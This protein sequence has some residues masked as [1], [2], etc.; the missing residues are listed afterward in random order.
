MEQIR[1]LYGGIRSSLGLLY[2]MGFKGLFPE[3]I[4]EV[5]NNMLVSVREDSDLNSRSVE[6]VVEDINKMI[7]LI[8]IPLLEVLRIQSEEAKKKNVK[9]NMIEG[10]EI[11]HEVGTQNEY[12]DYK[13]KM[14]VYLSQQKRR[15]DKQLKELAIMY[16]YPD[17]FKN[18]IPD[19]EMKRT[20]AGA[21]KASL[22][23]P[24]TTDLIAKDAIFQKDDGTVVFI[25]LGC[26]KEN[27]LEYEKKIYLGKLKT[28]EVE[29]RTK[30]RERVTLE[31]K[32]RESIQTSKDRKGEPIHITV[33][34][35]YQNFEEIGEQAKTMEEMDVLLC[36]ERNAARWKEKSKAIYDI[37]RERA[38]F[39]DVITIS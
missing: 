27:L 2:P 39:E 21:L 31:N 22:R 20:I 32:V 28:T 38:R 12:V 17:N 14:D 23:A 6:K 10:E 33:N 34:T 7:T 15:D 30:M 3:E 13:K 24:R 26:H 16:V 9:K 29:T 35:V 25:L 18:E 11:P 4:Q 1:N 5:L 8:M 36:K 19:D 37:R